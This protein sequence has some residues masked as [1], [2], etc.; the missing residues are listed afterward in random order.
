M[1]NVGVVSEQHIEYWDEMLNVHP[2]I[3]ND[4]EKLRDYIRFI[5]QELSPEEKG[6][7]LG[8][9]MFIA[10]E[11]QGAVAG[12]GEAVEVNRISA[13]VN[14]RMFAHLLY[15][16][17]MHQLEFVDDEVKENPTPKLIEM[18]QSVMDKFEITDE[19]TF[20]EIGIKGIEFMADEIL[21]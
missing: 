7:D 6:A 3:D 4:I 11:I 20:T 14:N 1:P 17:E 19:L 15:N 8:I 5:H 21:D 18:A 13:E 9:S 10:D 12:I 2:L 16:R